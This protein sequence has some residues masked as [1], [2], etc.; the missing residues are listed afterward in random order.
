MIVGLTGGIGSGKSTITQIFCQLK[1]PIYEADTASKRIID[2][3]SELQ[4]ELIKLLGNEVMNESRINRRFMALKIFNNK[5]LLKKVNALIH[6]AVGNDFEK[7]LKKQNPPYVIKEAA[8]LFES[9]AHK[10]C[11]KIVVVAATPQEMRIN[12]IVKRG[13]VSREE[14]I[15]RMNNQWPEE[16]KVKKADYVIYNDGGQSIIKQVISIHESIIRQSNQK[17]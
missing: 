7:W 11:D 15:I 3:D 1:I 14:A 2:T 17:S 16:Q 13:N 8:I 4:K 5:E 10:Q 6:P 12:R 9:G